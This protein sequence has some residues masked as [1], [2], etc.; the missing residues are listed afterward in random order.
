[1]QHKKTEA[2]KVLAKSAWYRPPTLARLKKG[3]RS[4][5][6]KMNYWKWEDV[7]ANPV[8]YGIFFPYRKIRIDFPEL[9]ME[10]SNAET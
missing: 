8:P 6:S 4:T 1:M 9:E 2:Q 5:A 3:H 7:K 10:S